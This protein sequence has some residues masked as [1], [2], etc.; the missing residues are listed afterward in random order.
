MSDEAE[1]LA[2]VAAVLGDHR[3][4]VHAVNGLHWPMAFEAAWLVASNRQQPPRLPAAV[5]DGQDRAMQ[6][7]EVAARLAVGKRTVERLV[8]SG[9]LPTVDIGGA[10]RV[11]ESDLDAYLAGRPVRTVA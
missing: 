3:R 8:A 7:A 2:F 6:Y 4:R 9:E 11:R 5:H 1:R 10:P